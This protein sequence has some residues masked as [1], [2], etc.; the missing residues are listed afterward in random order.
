ME[1]ADIRQAKEILAYE[2]TK[3]T[4]GESEAQKARVASHSLFG[5]DSEDVE[6]VPTTV[7]A[8]N[9]LETGIRLVDLLVEVGLAPSKSEA[10]RLIRQGGAYINDRQT[11]SI[12]TLLTVGDFSSDGLLLRAGKKRYHRVVVKYMNSC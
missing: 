10:R 6:S 12:E 5:R 9:R 4:H 2:A 1:G 3:I 7:I 11:E 8:R